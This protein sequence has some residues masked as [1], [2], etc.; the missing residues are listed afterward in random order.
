MHRSWGGVLAG[1]L[2]VVPSLFILI[3]LSWVYIAAGGPL[4]ESTHGAT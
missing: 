2:F 4:V 1:V 3:G